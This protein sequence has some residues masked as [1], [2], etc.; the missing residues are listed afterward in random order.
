MWNKDEVEGKGKKIKGT[1][2]DKVGEIS[3]NKKLESEG[4]ADRAAGKV[5]EGI[6]S[7][8]RKAGETVKKIG[9]KI[10]GK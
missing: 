7:A 8:R 5:Q 3:G 2:K 9:N 1:I 4:E 6:G 10:A